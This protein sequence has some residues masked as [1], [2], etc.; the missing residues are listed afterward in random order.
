MKKNRKKIEK[1][2]FVRKSNYIFARNFFES[3]LMRN[4]EVMK[5]IMLFCCFLSASTPAQMYKIEGTLYDVAPYGYALLVNLS[6][7][8]VEWEGATSNDA[9]SKFSIST[10]KGNYALCL[11]CGFSTEGIYI[12]ISLTSDTILAT[13]ECVSTSI[14]LYDVLH[15]FALERQEEEKKYILKNYMKYDMLSVLNILKIFDFRTK[16]ETSHIGRV[17]VN[18]VVLEKNFLELVDYFKNMQANDVEYIS[19]LPPTEE[20]PGGIIK[21]VTSG[22]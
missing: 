20:A 6:D 21:I 14:T 4:I 18:G 8:S 17:E 2:L 19:T 1:N 13:F 5:N 9:Y 3:E 10:K 7:N 15:G 12:P 11:T 16:Q 22:K